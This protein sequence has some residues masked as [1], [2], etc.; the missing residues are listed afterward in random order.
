MISLPEIK[1]H[2]VEG[3]LSHNGWTVWPNQYFDNL[4][5]WCKEIDGHN[6][7]LFVPHP[8]KTVEGFSITD[9][10][11]DAKGA[12][13]KSEQQIERELHAVGRYGWPEEKTINPLLLSINDGTMQE[14][15]YLCLTEGE[16]Y[17]I[18]KDFCKA[19]FDWYE[20]NTNGIEEGW[21][22][23]NDAF[24]ANE[25]YWYFTTPLD[26]LPLAFEVE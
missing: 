22:G 25:S 24:S 14:R 19:A 23:I 10:I 1:W 6:Y 12:T 7:S 2:Q 15:E 4:T 17:K 18:L 3:W 8:G 16:A 26:S 5:K 20:E 11:H 13:R 21:W 9:F